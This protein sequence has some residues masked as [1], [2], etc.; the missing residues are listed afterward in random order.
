MAVNDTLNPND[1][2][3]Q[4]KDQGPV[5]QSGDKDNFN[6]IDPAVTLDAD[7]NLWLSFGSFWSGI[8]LIQLDPATGKQIKPDSKI[9][10]LAHA[11]EIEAP[12]IYH[13]G[14]NYY[15]FVNWGLCCRGVNSTY[16]IRMGRSDKITGPYLDKDGKDML[17]DGGTLIAGSDGPFIGPGHAGILEKDGKSW[18]SMH[19]YDATQRGRSELA[20]RELH[21]TDDGWP[22]LS[23]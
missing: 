3:Y 17:H 10:S 18:M 23:N 1:K 4:W 13:H 22:T 15:L 6:A 8:K 21:W 2:N 14:N 20:I 5:V 9:Y 12:Y 11:K 16:N 7:K 19:F